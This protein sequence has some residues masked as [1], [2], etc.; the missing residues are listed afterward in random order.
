MEWLTEGGTT[1]LI[2]PLPRSRTTTG[3]MAPD[4]MGPKASEA[5]WAATATSAFDRLP[6]PA[7]RSDS[8]KL[9]KGGPDRVK[10][11]RP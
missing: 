5:P 10:D 3:A 11:E 7:P 8:Y 1:R 2:M 4:V 6:T 9:T